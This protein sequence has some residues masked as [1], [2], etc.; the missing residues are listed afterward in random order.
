[1]SE[2][3]VKY[4]QPDKVFETAVE[5]TLKWEGGYVNDPDDRG[6][7]TKY[8][9][10]KRAYPEHDIESLLVDDAKR[11]FR[12]DYWVRCRINEIKDAVVAAKVFDLAVNCGPRRAVMMLQ[13]A[14]RRAN[15]HY[16]E[17]DGALGERT[18]NEVNQSES[19]AHLL[20]ELKL[21]AV[22]YYAGLNRPKFLSGWLR[23]ALTVLAFL[24]VL[25][26][27]CVRS[28]FAGS[29]YEFFTNIFLQTPI[30]TTPGKVVTVSRDAARLKFPLQFVVTGNFPEGELDA[31]AMLH[32][33]KKTAMSQPATA[34]PLA[35]PIAWAPVF[36]PWKQGDRLV[37][38]RTIAH[39]TP[40]LLFD[41]YITLSKDHFETKKIS[42]LLFGVAPKGEVQRGDISRA[43]VVQVVI[44]RK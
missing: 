36:F 14:S 11:I 30:E 23:R 10:S 22:A 13:E 18:L 33:R 2:D 43:H 38:Y 27:L 21:Q 6:G 15:G 4:A 25:C 7:E 1:M 34:N 42:G 17:V 12:R 26:G 9:I 31:F 40:K 16:L 24:C 19:P 44:T 37:P 41:G 28:S 39:A 5:K 35:K 3:P 20:A 32:Y 29:P 8:G